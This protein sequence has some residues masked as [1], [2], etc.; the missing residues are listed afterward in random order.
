MRLEVSLKLKERSVEA[1][2]LYSIMPH[3]VVFILD[4]CGYL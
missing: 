3:L 1:A 4:R 2:R